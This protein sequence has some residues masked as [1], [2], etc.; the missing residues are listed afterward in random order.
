[1]LATTDLMVFMELPARNEPM[2]APRRIV[3]SAGRGSMRI[4]ILPPSMVYPASTAPKTT[5]RPMMK[6]I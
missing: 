1:M 4:L 5:T 3:P 2:A 6:N